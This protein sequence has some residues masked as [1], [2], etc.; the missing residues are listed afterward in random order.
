[1]SASIIT[2]EDLQQFKT[3]LFAELM[4]I[5]KKETQPIKKWLK[6]QEVRK[7]LQVSPGTLQTLRINGTLQYTKLGG[8]VYYDF[9]HIE[10]VMINNLRLS[11]KT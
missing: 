11:T 6:S 2:Y 4:T 10:K 7:L 5:L 1:M 9:E 8:V 3:E